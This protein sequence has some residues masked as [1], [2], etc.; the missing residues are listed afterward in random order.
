M[1]KASLAGAWRLGLL[2]AGLAAALVAGA[3]PAAACSPLPASLLSWSQQAEAIVVGRV[4][5][6]TRDVA[7]VEVLETWRGVRIP[8]ALTLSNQRYG[9][10][11]ASC[12]VQR[13]V[14]AQLIAGNE[15]AQ[16]GSRPAGRLALQRRAR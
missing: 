14:A 5:S 12:A 13:D 4:V 7:A 9:P 2:T 15:F 6:A 11:D 16:G 8:A 1:S 10:P 3:R